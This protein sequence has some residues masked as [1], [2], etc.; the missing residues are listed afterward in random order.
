MTVRFERE[1]GGPTSQ[2]FIREKMQLG[3]GK[4]KEFQFRQGVVTR[5]NCTE[6]YF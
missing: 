5:L 6:I 4:D 2:Y 1:G 3:K